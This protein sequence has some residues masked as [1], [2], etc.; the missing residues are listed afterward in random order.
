MSTSPTGPLR[1]GPAASDPWAKWG[2]LMAAVW[3]VFLIYPGISLT[4]SVADE[5][6]VI[7]GW[8]G[9][10]AFAVAYICGFVTGMRGGWRAPTRAVIALFFMA[11]GCA[12]LTIPAI[13]WGAASFLPFLMAYAAYGIGSVWHW[14]T[15]AISILVITAYAVAE[16]TRGSQPPWILIGIVMMMA[17]VNTINTWLIGRS[18]AED[19][20]RM[21]LATSEERE[22][23]A[24]DVHDVLGH[25]LTVVKLKAQ[26]AARLIDRDPT[27]ARA[28]LDDI[29]R[30]TGEAIAS[31][32]ST[33]TGI[34]AHTL[35]EQLR[36]SHQALSATG[37]R[38]RVTGS[39]LTLSP[40]Q[41]IPAAWILREATTNILRHA[42]AAQVT[43]TI[44][45][46][47]LTVEDDGVGVA[48]PGSELPDGNGVRGMRERASAAGATFTVTPAMAGQNHRRGTKVRVIW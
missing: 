15:T 43:I 13:G 39:P 20:L 36:L 30:I 23:I 42:E 22:T 11:T 4:E 18:V 14:A 24:R 34:R 45:P 1:S 33:V 21:E 9:L 35:E 27:A 47:E 29:A 25:S 12:L 44:E 48:V 28:E 46:G 38:V 16:L 31:V 8:F 19:D 32:R 10:I 7:A 41:S 5:I 3:L 6:W 37:V 26:L 40:A 2:W 17:V